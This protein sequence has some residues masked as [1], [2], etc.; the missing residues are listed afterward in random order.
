MQAKL[1]VA[2][3]RLTEVEF[4]E[5]SGTIVAAVSTNPNYPQPW[6]PQVTTIA[7]LT[8]ALTNYVS[9]Y[10]DSLTKDIIKVASRESHRLVL[11]N[12]L[13]QLAPY[14][15]LIAQGSVA[16]LETTGYDLRHDTT[17]NSGVD[18]LPAPLD[19]R[20][21]HGAIPSTL[22]VKA[23]RLVGAASYEV[24]L[25]QVDP[26]IEANWTHAT[27]SKTATHI[28]LTNLTPTH[29][30]WVRLRAI[31]TNGPGLWTAPLNIIVV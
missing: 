4:L 18:P 26:L 13:K 24:Q 5:K 30:Y 16:K 9:A 17:P 7:L 19:F 8:T 23:G 14:F 2:F 10:H 29:A 27:S 3:D 22:D 15:E 12:M 31:G 21:A 11:S 1:I 6:L 25:T 28:Q 20:V